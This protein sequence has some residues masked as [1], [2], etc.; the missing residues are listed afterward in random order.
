MSTYT[1]RMKNNTFAFNHAVA[2]FFHCLFLEHKAEL[3]FIWASVVS[4]I[5]VITMKFAELRMFS[6]VMVFACMASF[7]MANTDFGFFYT[8]IPDVEAINGLFVSLNFPDLRGWVAVGGD[9]CLD[10]WEGVNCVLMNI[11]SLKLSG[12]NL[13]GNL[14]NSLGLFAS[15]IDIDLSNNSIG[16]SIPSVLPPNLLNLSLDK[17]NLSGAIPDAFELMTSLTNLD[18]SANNL[19]GQLPPSFGNLSSINSLHLQNNTLTGV[20]DVLQDIPLLDLNVENNLF[21]GPIPVKLLKVPN[22]RKDGNPFNTTVISSPPLAFPPLSV[23]EPGSA[24]TPKGPGY[25]PTALQAQKPEKIKAVYTS[26]RAI[27]VTVSVVVVVLVVVGSCLLLLAC[28]KRRQ[29]NN[30]GVEKPNNIQVEKVPKGLVATLRDQFQLD[31]KKLEKSLKLRDEHVIDMTRVPTRSR[32]TMEHDIDAKFIPL[33]PPPPPPPCLP[34]NKVIGNLVVH[35]EICTR[36]SSIKSL[37]STSSVKIFSIAT[38]Q[39]Y[40]NSF[41]EEK[42]LGKGTF[43][44]V[45]NAE[46]PD[47]KLLAVK[48]LNN[49]ATRQQTD[50][51]F[52]DLVSSI[53]KIRHANIVELVGYC[54][55]HGQRFLVHEFCLM[56]TLHDALHVD[57]EIHSKLSWNARV[58]IA[59]GAAR[60]LQ[61][62]HEVCQPPIVHQNFRSG[63]ILLD[64]KLAACVSDCGLAH[65]SSGYASELAGRLLSSN[66]Y[67]AP[68]FELG[69]YTCKS[70]IYSFGVVMLELLTGRKSYDKSLS[71]FE[72]SL[73]QWASSR[74]HDIDSLSGMVD[75]TLNGAYTAKALSRFA[76]IIARCVQAEPEFRP[77]MSE[78]VQD[79]LHMI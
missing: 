6:G 79:L 20:L 35:E 48:K 24:E 18:L 34:G 26:K 12:K 72:Q 13:G 32:N 19:S 50:E 37:T 76:D 16:G 57:T 56:G 15:I 46:L 78:I 62:L 33:Q 47:G 38:L 63:N 30:N 67:A 22:F 69:S 59:L 27:M 77:G 17:N 3:N 7:S 25:S 60:A 42:L 70:D 21:S 31:K 66:G 23:T 68:E 75:T 44:S 54:N 8:D 5:C 10:N 1:E 41:S 45:Y 28:F 4:F 58:R 52:I 71:R 65:L 11:T 51:E 53:S 73:V 2:F 64:D 14:E 36:S 43:G 55:E 40:T 39:Q 74:L 9:P 29:A 49:M 61:Y